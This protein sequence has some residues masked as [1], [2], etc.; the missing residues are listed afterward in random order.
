MGSLNPDEKPIPNVLLINDNHRFIQTG[1]ESSLSDTYIGR[2]SVTFDYDND[3]DLDLFIVNQSSVSSSFEGYENLSSRLY[4]N[5]AAT[6]NWMKIKLE[7]SRSDVNGIGS[8]VEVYTDNVLMIREID[9][10]S[11]HESQNSK[12]AH[13]GMKEYKTA[14]SII[15]KWTSGATQKLFDL[16]VNQTITM[17]EPFEFTTWEKFVLFLYTLPY[18]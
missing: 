18:V 5:D 14:D 4:R 11:S 8:R 3:G 1:A 2:G 6:G 17:Q 10:G 12:I 9:G 15:V 13:F 16:E 7:G